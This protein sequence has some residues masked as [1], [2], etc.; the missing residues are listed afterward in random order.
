MY[1]AISALQIIVSILLVIIVLFQVGKG[2][3]MGSS[4]GSTSSQALFGGAGPA[5][6]MTKITI[7]LAAIFMASALYLTY[8]SRHAQSSSVMDTVPAV[9]ETPKEPTPAETAIPVTV[10]AVKGEEAAA[11]TVKTGKIEEK[12][13]TVKP[14][15]KPA[16]KPKTPTTPAPAVKEVK[17]VTKPEAKTEAKA[18]TPEPVKEAA[19]KAETETK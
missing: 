1:T 6:L 17:P 14:V 3:T 16:A 10:P 18:A 5:T 12:A 13:Q 8:Q 7:L 19:P 15:T 4:L 2:A 9:V 11:A